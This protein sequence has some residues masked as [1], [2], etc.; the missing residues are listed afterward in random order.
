MR[1]TGW[2]LMVAVL[3]AAGCG[4]D[5]GTGDA[6]AG[7]SPSTAVDVERVGPFEVMAEATAGPGTTLAE[8]LEV[9]DGSVLLGSTFPAADRSGRNGGFE[10]LVLL[11]G[12]PVAVFNDYVEQ[13]RALGM[14][15]A[16]GGC[17]GNPQRIHCINALA[18]SRDGESLLVVL[19]RGPG[20]GYGPVSHVAL[21]YLPP[22]TPDLSTAEPR[23]VP[24]TTP[25]PVV[26]L[27][28]G[29]VARPPATDIAVAVRPTGSEP[30]P[31]VDGTELVGPPGPCGC[32]AVGWSAVLRV[33]GDP[34]Q[35]VEDWAAALGAP[36]A[37]IEATA[38]G[39][40]KVLQASLGLVGAG[41]TELRAVTEDGVTH[42]LVAV[43]RS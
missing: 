36:G 41:G 42:L 31:L 35:A 4:G 10:A 2:A 33:T 23:P 15:P 29:P 14:S 38:V 43:A 20:A 8:G 34:R 1:G 39:G 40:R 6:A 18:D 19:V 22:G 11:T 25:L 21:R 27:P 3:L 28:A 16:P 32:A 12:D 26:S 37:A 30:V 24:P 5:A 17:F 9:A 13:A 7:S